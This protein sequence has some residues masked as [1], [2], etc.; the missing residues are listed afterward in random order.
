MK[1]NITKKRSDSEQKLAFNLIVLRRDMKL[2][3]AVTP[4]QSTQGL[5]EI[6]RSQNS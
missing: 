6:S 1:C 2:I 5:L 3:L 4:K